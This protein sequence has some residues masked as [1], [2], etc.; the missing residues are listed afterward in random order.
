MDKRSQALQCAANTCFV[1]YFLT[2]RQNF[3][4]KIDFGDFETL[5]NLENLRNFGKSQIP[6]FSK[7]EISKILK[8]FLRFRKI[9][10]FEKKNLDR[11]KIFF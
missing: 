10:T 11:K 3:F 5:E 8:K 6:K 7:S 1:I 4:W 2:P 9:M